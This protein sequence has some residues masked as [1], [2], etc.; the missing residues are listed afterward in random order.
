MPMIRFNAED[1]PDAERFD[2]WRE[3][4]VGSMADVVRLDNPEKRHLS[5]DRRYAAL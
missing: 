3:D 2:R 1:Y 5:L 4:F